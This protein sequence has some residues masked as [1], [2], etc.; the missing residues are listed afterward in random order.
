MLLFQPITAIVS[1][2]YLQYL[3]TLFIPIDV[4][5]DDKNFPDQY[6]FKLS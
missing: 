6:F 2:L 4:L 5:Y 1:W 3:K